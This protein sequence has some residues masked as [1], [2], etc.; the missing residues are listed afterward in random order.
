[1]VKTMGSTNYSSC[2]DC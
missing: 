2:K 1:M